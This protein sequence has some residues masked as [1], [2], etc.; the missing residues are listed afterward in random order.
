MHLLH[1]HVAILVQYELSGFDHFW[2]S[3][4][5]YILLQGKSVRVVGMCAGIEERLN[6]LLSRPNCDCVL[7]TDLHLA[8]QHWINSL[9][10]RIRDASRS[11]N[12]HC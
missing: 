7:V 10:W 4:V 5:S 1:I 3:V 11:G 6:A 2:Y 8:P 12:K 9:T